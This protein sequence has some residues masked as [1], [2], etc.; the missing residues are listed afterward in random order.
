MKSDTKYAAHII[1]TSILNVV[2]HSTLYITLRQHCYYQSLQE[3]F[4]MGKWYHHQAGD[5]N[6]TGNKSKEIYNWLP[7][8]STDLALTFQKGRGWKE[9]AKAEHINIVLHEDQFDQSCLTPMITLHTSIRDLQ[10]HLFT[11]IVLPLD[12]DHRC[13]VHHSCKMASCGKTCLLMIHD[14]KFQN[15]STFSVFVSLF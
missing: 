5:G 7:S 9:P 2:T 8:Y 6:Q 3:E 12:L 15:V 10:I 11:N 13:E 14:L 4:S 1:M